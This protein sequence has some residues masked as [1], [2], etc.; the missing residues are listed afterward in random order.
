MFNKKSNKNKHKNYLYKIDKMLDIPEEVIS[1][2]TKI[3]IM[4]FNSV[5]IEN[6]KIVLEYQEIFIR[7]KIHNGFINM[8]GLNLKIDEMNNDDILIVGEIE[9]IEF[10]KI[11]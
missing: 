8:N 11:E 6:Y 1:D 10:E 9:E 7:I 2:E 5:L 4:G 3:T